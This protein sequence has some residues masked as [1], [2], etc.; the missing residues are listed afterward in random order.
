VAE[1]V[2][3]AQ[4]GSDPATKMTWGDVSSLYWLIRRDDLVAGRFDVARFTLQTG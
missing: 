2:L 1:W 4:F 3:L